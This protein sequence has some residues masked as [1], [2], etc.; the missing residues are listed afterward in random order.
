MTLTR[1][2]AGSAACALIAGTLLLAPALAQ[3][4]AQPAEQWFATVFQPTLILDPT[5]K[6]IAPGQRVTFTVKPPAGT[7]GTISY[8]W[9][10][11]G[12]TSTLSSGDGIVG[13]SITTASTSVDLVTT[14]SD[15]GTITVKVVATLTD[16]GGHKSELGTA[17]AVITLDA[18]TIN[19]D[20]P[21]TQKIVTTAS[22]TPGKVDVL[23]GWVV[24]VPA[25]AW[26]QAIASTAVSSAG[27]LARL[28]YNSGAP[29]INQGNSGDGTWVPYG[30][31]RNGNGKYYNLGA[32][33]MFLLEL[34]SGEID[35]DGV[36]LASDAI[37]KSLDREPV[38][39]VTF[40]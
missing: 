37:K 11:T 32:G 10:Q 33:T 18:A 6:T 3:P 20:V 30:Y 28:D 39:H 4:S 38:D 21:V 36:Q 26:I 7:V 17:Q 15:S 14:P 5:A 8:A 19:V 12:A 40:S 23:G 9:T 24:A 22:A 2:T 34:H 29:V 16:A 35:P 1:F 13:N 25:G 31:A 27:T